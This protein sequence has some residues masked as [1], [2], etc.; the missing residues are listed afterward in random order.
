MS[1]CTMCRPMYMDNIKCN[2]NFCV[3]ADIG[4]MVMSI[5]IQ[6]YCRPMNY[7]CINDL[8]VINVVSLHL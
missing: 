2:R 5:C 3:I 6:N 8:I 4:D 7:I 1:V